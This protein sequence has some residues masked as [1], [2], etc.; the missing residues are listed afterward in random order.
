MIK[1]SAMKKVAIESPFRF[2]G[3]HPSYTYQELVA[4]NIRYAQLCLKYVLSLGHAPYA[5]HLLYTQSQAF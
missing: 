5:S 4:Q 2:L 3:R 1:T